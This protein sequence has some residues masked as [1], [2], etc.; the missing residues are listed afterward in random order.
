[1]DLL[2]LI[3]I[4]SGMGLIVGAILMK[5][6]IAVFIDPSSVMIVLGGTFASTCISYSGKSIVVALKD[7]ITVFALLIQRLAGSPIRLKK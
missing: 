6:S 7:M 2:T 1:M 5:T 4:L 3:G